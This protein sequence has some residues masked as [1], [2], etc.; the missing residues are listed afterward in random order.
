MKSEGM[1]GLWF[2]DHGDDGNSI[3]LN[4]GLKLDFVK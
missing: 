4:V 2:R 3:V 1:E